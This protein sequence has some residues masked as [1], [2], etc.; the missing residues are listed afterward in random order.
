MSVVKKILGWTIVIVCLP[1][2]LA[3]MLVNDAVEWIAGLVLGTL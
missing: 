1:L 2:G 3:A